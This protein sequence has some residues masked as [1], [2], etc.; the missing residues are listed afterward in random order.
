MRD[1]RMPA[2]EHSAIRIR[3]RSETSALHRE[4]ERQLALL[5]PD[6]S[7]ERYR[8]V[9]CAFHGF[10]AP[11]E[12]R[13]PGL[14]AA[15][16]PLGIPLPVRTALL[17]RDLR[18]LSLPQAA[19]EALPRCSELPRLTGPE[20]LAGC[21]Y[22]LEGASLGGQV[23]ARAL[24]RNLGLREDGGAA[25]FAGGRE[26]V[27]VRWNRVVTWLDEV[28]R[29]GAILDEMVAAACETFGTLARWMRQQEATR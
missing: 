27:A 25:F 18:A 7:L 23:V 9:L 28:A 12:R 4:L 15:A 3:L 16:P 10:Y 22:V 8:R 11:V 1:V 26:D 17:E 2:F 5:A 24:D 21:L 6:L 20:H 14:A 13:L 29:G 19:I